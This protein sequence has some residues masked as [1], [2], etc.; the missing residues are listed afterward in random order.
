MTLFD[1]SLYEFAT[2]VAAAPGA[3]LTTRDVLH[4]LRETFR[5][6]RARNSKSTGQSAAALPVLI[7]DD[8]VVGLDGTEIHDTESLSTEIL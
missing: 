7:A 1:S 8:D 3:N 6:I 2:A 5:G 4:I